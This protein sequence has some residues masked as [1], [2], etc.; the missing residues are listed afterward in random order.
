MKEK[1]NQ[2]IEQATLKIQ[3]SADL[4][5]INDLKVQY[6]GKAGEITALLKGMK[7][8]PNEQKPEIGKYV[9]KARDTITDLITK[10]MNDLQQKA[11]NAKMMKLIF[12][13]IISLMLCLVT[14]GIYALANNIFKLK[15]DEKG[16]RLCGLHVF[17]SCLA[18]TVL[19]S[20]LVTLTMG[21]CPLFM[22]AEPVLMLAGII[23]LI[24]CL[25]KAAR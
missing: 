4:N 7:D 2:L 24:V 19:S 12:Y 6:L 3:E 25:V 1:I 5:A 21:T 14:Y 11:M 13:P 9:N 17:A 16:L 18:L 22:F 10:K 23:T 15:P 20:T 8:V